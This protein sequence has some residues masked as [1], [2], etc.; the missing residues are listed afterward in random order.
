[1]DPFDDLYARVIVEHS[2]AVA[3]GQL[4]LIEGPT[5]AAPLAEAIHRRVLAAGAHPIVVLQPNGYQDAKVRLAS[6]EVLGRPDWLKSIA[7][8][9]VDA[10]V[11][12]LADWNTRETSD[13]PAERATLAWKGTHRALQP[14]LQRTARG[15]ATWLVA[16]VPTDS[17]A[18]EAGVSLAEYREILSRALLLDQPDPV[19]AWRRVAAR[20][21]RLVERLSTVEELR[22][23]APG[24]DLRLRVGGRTWV[25]AHGEANL[26]DGEVFT[27]PIEDSAEG[28][29]TFGFPSIWEGREVVGARLRFERGRVVEATARSGQAFLEAAIAMDDG[30]RRIGEIAIGMNDGIERP[31][32]DTIFDEKIGGSFH[33]AL[34]DSYE[35]TGGVNE[36]DLHWDLVCDLRS[37]GE[38]LADG[39]PIYRDGGFAAGLALDA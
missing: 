15:E 28:E 38:I 19:A 26:P 21:Q 7:Y 2:L 8:E 25:S 24:T 29:V 6:D 5:L 16:Q 4:V 37:G 9:Q 18:Q 31:M 36:S 11:K 32:G 34:G 39:E 3:A 22:F 27:G 17:Y 35:E 10:R 1:M 23:R 14:L 12:L 13:Q 30:A 33:L 20:Q